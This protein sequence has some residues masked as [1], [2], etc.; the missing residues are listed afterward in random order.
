MLT[1]SVACVCLLALA[2]TSA[3]AVS[4]MPLSENPGGQSPEAS[5]EQWWQWVFDFDLEDGG[6]PIN[7][8][9]GAFQ[10]LNQT[11]PVYMLGG[12][13]GGPAERAFTAKAGKVFMVPLLNQLCLGDLESPCGAPNPNQDD[14]RESL[15]NADQLF[16]RING[17]PVIN[18]MTSTEVDAADSTLRIQT[19][20]FAVNLAENSYLAA[21]FGITPGL[22]PSSFNYGFYAFVKLG[23]GTH[24]LEYGGGTGGFNTSVKATITLAPV[25]LPAALPLLAM[26]FGALCLAARRKSAAA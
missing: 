8:A 16:L 24:V 25:P 20:L 12:T 18:A 7:D 2:A 26:G 21:L 15:D 4:L 14:A 6:D 17:T 9:T 10:N 19:D 11:Y 13:F 3:G 5:A 22:Y 23:T 1:R